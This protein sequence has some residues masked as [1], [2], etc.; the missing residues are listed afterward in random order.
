MCQR[1]K[2]QIETPVGKL[3]ANEVLEKLWTHLTVDFITK[4]LLVARK[5]MILVVCNWLSKMTY[6][7]VTI[8]RISA[9]ELVWLFRDNVQK[10]H[11]LPQSVILDR[12]PQFIVEL[13]KKLNRM[14]DI[15]MKLLTSFHSQTDSQTE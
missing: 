15:E 1:M 9:E 5:D 12:K 7:V 3:M 6:F 2:N 4:L 10:L 13:M 11:E 14:L 8:E